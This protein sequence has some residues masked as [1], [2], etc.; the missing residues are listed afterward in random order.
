V[1]LDALES[2]HHLGGIGLDVFPTEPWPQL[3]RLAQRPHVILTPHAAG[4]HPAL[5]IAV[6]GEVTRTVTAWQEGQ[7]LEFLV[8]GS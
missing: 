8:L 5:G 1:D 7:A 3:Q 6:A 2:A 4:Y